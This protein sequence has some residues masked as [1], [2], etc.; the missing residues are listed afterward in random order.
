MAIPNNRIPLP[1]GVGLRTWPGDQA[2]ST[3]PTWP[4][5][6]P[7]EDLAEIATE[8]ITSAFEC[9]EWRPVWV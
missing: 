4:W 7:V 8:A 1:A 2:I 9:S 6:G 5:P 3:T